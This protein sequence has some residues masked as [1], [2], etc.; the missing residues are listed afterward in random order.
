MPPKKPLQEKPKKRLDIYD[1]ENVDIIH[2]Q[3]EDER[4]Q[5]ERDQKI[6]NARD[7]RRRQEQRDLVSYSPLE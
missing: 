2:P 6:A 3:E 4:R 7:A 1:I 5:A